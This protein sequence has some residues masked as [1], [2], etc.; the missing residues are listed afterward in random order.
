M[1]QPAGRSLFRPPRSMLLM[2]VQNSLKT[3]RETTNPNVQA[4]LGTRAQV[5]SRREKPILTQARD[6]IGET[7]VKIYENPLVNAIARIPGASFIIPGA[8]I[9]TTVR[10]TAA[11][12]K[13]R[14]AN[15]RLLTVLATRTSQKEVRKIGEPILEP[16]PRA[17]NT[18]AIKGML[19]RRTAPTRSIRHLHLERALH[20]VRKA[21]QNEPIL[22][23][24]HRIRRPGQ[25]AIAARQAPE[26]FGKRAASAMPTRS[27]KLGAVPR[28]RVR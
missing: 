26:S 4:Y 12:H 9:V 24:A 23:N 3:K 27:F 20:E 10:A 18:Q 22:F 14:L 21:S 8:G 6:V 1:A 17:L 13:E 19:E 11:E 25:S 16:K 28:E 5:A 7:A 2:A 15:T